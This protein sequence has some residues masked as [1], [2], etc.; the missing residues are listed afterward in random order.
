MN[1][2]NPSNLDPKLKEAYERIMG[3]SPASAQ[4]QKP[5]EPPAQ[6][7]QPDIQTPQQSVE[8]LQQ[9]PPQPFEPPAQPET[10]TPSPQVPQM[11]TQ[12]VEE[13]ATVQNITPAPD[14]SNELPQ[15]PLLKGSGIFV[16]PNPSAEEV[17]NG[18]SPV[19]PVKKESK[20][21]PLLIGFFGIILFVVYAIVWAKVFGL[22]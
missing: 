4:S 3:T 11:E 8:G 6:N 5:P 17:V 18:D 13:Q 16:N 14:F 21:M 10:Q 12:I 9:I 20:L 7:P 2:N 1:P 22:F 15:S 19:K